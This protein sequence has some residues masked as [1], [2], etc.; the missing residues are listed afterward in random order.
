[1]RMNRPLLLA[2]LALAA[3][4]ALPGVAVADGRDD[5]DDDRGHGHHGHGHHGHGHHHHHWHKKKD[6]KVQLL[7]LNDFHGALE[8]PSGSGGRVTDVVNGQQVTIDAGGVEY[9]ATHV[10]ALERGVKHSLV[11]S[12][13]DLIGGTPFTSALFHDEPT[14]EAM[15]KIGLDINGVGNHEFDEG[16]QE[17]LRMQYGGCHPNPAPPSETCANG[18]F[19][20]ANFDFL[21][22]NVVRRNNGRTLFPAYEIRKFGGVKIGFIGMT[23]E[24]TPSIVSPSGITNLQF[25]DEADTANRYARELRRRH[26]VEAIVVL[27]HEGGAENPLSPQLNDCNNITGP[28]FDIVHR[29][30][31]DVDLFVTGHS[32]QEYNCVIDGRPVTSAMSNGRLITDIDLELDGRSEDVEE[33]S[34][35]NTIVTRTVAKAPDLTSLLTT[36]QQ[37]AAPIA[38]VPVGQISASILRESAPILGRNAL[39]NLIADAQ[40]A[41]TDDADRGDADLALMNPG[42]VRAD[43][44][45]DSPA[46]SGGQ[47]TYGEAFAVQPFNNIVT[48]QSFT[49]AQLLEVLKD[50]WCQGPTNVLLPSSTLAY[51]YDRTDAVAIAGQPCASVNNPVS[52][53][54]VNGV[55]LDPN[56]TYRVTTNNFLADGGD[57]FASLTAGT[58]RTT[59]D[60]FDIDSL[61]RYLE[62]TLTG[63][64]IG[65]PPTDRITVVE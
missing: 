60:D 38:G 56:A 59:L 39:G 36:Y 53:V 30:T 37:L 18:R 64:P 1:M 7:G 65:P 63:A 9:F 58:N 14:I 44:V 24:G 8:P 61:V 19:R 55:A 25:L 34:V 2:L 57:S 26:D 33:V 23:L 13:G 40:L 22:A 4:L 16:E 21:A 52:N 29:T 51:T 54:R 17:L 28:I 5:D 46:G 48:T 31:D 35:N 6:V 47:V 43:L 20:G 11:V 45:F 62:P 42:G 50:Q 27:L 41:D 12:A 10:R 49:G 3:L 32:H 15:N